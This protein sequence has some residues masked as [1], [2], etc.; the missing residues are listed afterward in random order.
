MQ[1]STRFSSAREALLQVLLRALLIG[2]MIAA[3]FDDLCVKDI[4]GGLNEHRGF[5]RNQHRRRNPYRY[6]DRSR[7]R[8]SH[9]GGGRPY[10]LADRK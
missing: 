7:N 8:G 10:E 4:I 3:I 2:S 9:S 6:L 5:T 1:P